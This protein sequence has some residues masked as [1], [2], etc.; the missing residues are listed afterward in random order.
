MVTLSVCLIK[1]FLQVNPVIPSVIHH[2]QNHIESTLSN[3]YKFSSC[4]IET[5][6]YVHCED[7][8]LNSIAVY[9]KNHTLW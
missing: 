3:V 4:C 2:R 9:C 8:A 1:H 5:T 6:L 7:E